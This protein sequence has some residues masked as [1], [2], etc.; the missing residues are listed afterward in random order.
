VHPLLSGTRWILVVA[1]IQN[2]KVALRGPD[3]RRQLKAWT[4]CDGFA[5]CDLEQVRAEVAADRY[6]LPSVVD[7]F[8]GMQLLIKPDCRLD[9]TEVGGEGRPHQ[10]RQKISVLWMEF[11]ESDACRLAAAALGWTATDVWSALEN[12]F[13]ETVVRVARQPVILQVDDIE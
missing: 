4:F 11:F 7:R 6:D 9:R 2:G 3:A 13:D 8:A 1:E 12:E 5:E 10:H